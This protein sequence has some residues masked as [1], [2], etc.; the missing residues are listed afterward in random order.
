MFRLFKTFSSPSAIHF[1]LVYKVHKITISLQQLPPVQNSHI[2]LASIILIPI[3]Y[4]LDQYQ[5]IFYKC[6][7]NVQIINFALHPPPSLSQIILAQIFQHGCILPLYH[8]VWS[9]QLPLVGGV[10]LRS[11]DPDVVFSLAGHDYLTA[12]TSLG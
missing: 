5:T 10:V 1:R 11:H 3:R 2:A 12:R 7:L 8:A 4:G 9:Y 6:L